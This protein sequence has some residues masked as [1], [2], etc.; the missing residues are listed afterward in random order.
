[1]RVYIE[2]TDSG[3]IVYYA[4]YLRFM[5]RARTEFLRRA[6]INQSH[7]VNERHLVF[8]VRSAAIDYIAPA[9]LDDEL[10]VGVS[11]IE[12]RRASLLFSQPIFRLGESSDK[13]LCTGQ[14]RIACIDSG[15]GKPV[16]V[17]TEVSEALHRER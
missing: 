11:I 3:G 16:P 12:H 2:D 4:N 15:S 5:E 1:M 10:Q 13:P 6:G 7:L 17:P 8:V 14:V 9:R